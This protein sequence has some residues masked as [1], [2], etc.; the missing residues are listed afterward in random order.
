MIY[1]I[2][3]KLKGEIFIMKCAIY[4]RTASK[5]NQD[6]RLKTQTGRLEHLSQNG[7]GSYIIHILILDQVPIITKIY[8]Q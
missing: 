8:G 3:K 2:S 4:I 7:I 1:S 5:N 6:Y